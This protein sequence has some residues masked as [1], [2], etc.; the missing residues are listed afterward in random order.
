MYFDFARA[1]LA[2]CKKANEL[3]LLNV[4]FLLPVMVF[5][6]ASR[7][8]FFVLDILAIQ[9]KNRQTGNYHSASSYFPN[10]WSP[11]SLTI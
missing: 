11:A 7:R 3:I 8:V 4:K 10:R 2:V 5:K 6:L 9:H 1:V